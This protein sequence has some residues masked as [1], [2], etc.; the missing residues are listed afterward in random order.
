MKANTLNIEAILKDVVEE[1]AEESEN[2]NENL[3]KQDSFQSDGSFKDSSI[4]AN[5]MKNYD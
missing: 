4:L 5:S 2:E 1:E 3:S